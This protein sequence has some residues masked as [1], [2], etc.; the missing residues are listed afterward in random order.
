M[1]L[2][3][4]Y[5]MQ[6]SEE[7]RFKTTPK[8]ETNASKASIK[9]NVTVIVDR[10]DVLDGGNLVLFLGLE[11]AD[12]DMIDESSD[13]NNDST[14]DQY[15]MYEVTLNAKHKLV[16]IRGVRHS[17]NAQ[18]TGYLIALVQLL[19]PHIRRDLLAA[20][21]RNLVERGLNEE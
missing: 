8:N 13:G 20:N 19:T 2:K 4:F 16:S 7:L 15:M 3:Y 5:V 21:G 17:L 1:K 14:E 12:P 18:N 11:P 9:M 10:N 6:L